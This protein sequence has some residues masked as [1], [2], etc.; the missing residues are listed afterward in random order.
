MNIKERLAG[1]DDVL[2]G[3]LC[4]VAGLLVGVV[5]FC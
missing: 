5:F 4:F 1:G 3:A 2:I